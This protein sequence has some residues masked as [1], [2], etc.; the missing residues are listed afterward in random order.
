M[1]VCKKAKSIVIGFSGGTEGN[2][3]DWTGG[4]ISWH[5]MMGTSLFSSSSF[6]SCVRF[7]SQTVQSVLM[8]YNY[9]YSYL[10]NYDYDNDGSYLT[11]MRTEEALAYY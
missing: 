6:H 1:W 7:M 10:D 2:Y 8:K 4:L 11:L 5:L 9:C 3:I